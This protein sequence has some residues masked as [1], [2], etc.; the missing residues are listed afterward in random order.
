MKILIKF[1]ENEFDL[2]DLVTILKP[3]KE[4][5]NKDNCLSENDIV[6]IPKEIDIYLLE[7]NFDNIIKL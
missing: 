1:N 2:D 7:S 6:I 3:I 4:F 5:F